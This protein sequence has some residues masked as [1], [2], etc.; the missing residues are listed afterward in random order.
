MCFRL[1]GF[2]WKALA[3]LRKLDIL[4]SGS[5][6]VNV[7][8]KVSNTEEQQITDNTAE[9]FSDFLLYI[10]LGMPKATQ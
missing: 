8:V 4:A 5:S 9:L 6:M 10:E 1:D 3:Q 2:F 7:V